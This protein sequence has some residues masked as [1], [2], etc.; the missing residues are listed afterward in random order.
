MTTPSNPNERGTEGEVRQANPD[1]AATDRN[2]AAKQD[3]VRRDHDALEESVRRVEASVPSN[4]Q[5]ATDP[6]AAAKQ[7]QVR[8]DHDRLQESAR[9]V[10]NS[11][12]ADV[13][14][15]PVQPADNYV[16]DGRGNAGSAREHADS[17][18]ANADA[19]RESARRVENSVP[20]DVRNTPVQP[21]DD[22]RDR[23]RR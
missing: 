5:A 4:Q 11:V 19:A 23:D 6:A 8:A 3:Q 9:R 15:T 14:D 12:S 18:R 21:V 22:D 7:D 13:R 16:D 1:N 20:A 2:A 10:E 17:A